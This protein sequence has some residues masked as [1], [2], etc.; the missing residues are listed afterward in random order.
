MMEEKGQRQHVRISVTVRVWWGG[1]RSSAHLL[2]YLVYFVFC[3]AKRTRWLLAAV[4]HRIQ[5][6]EWGLIE[7]LPQVS[8]RKVTL[9]RNIHQSSGIALSGHR[10]H[11]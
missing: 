5:E 10:S 11:S 1:T 7:A 3:D 8:Q 2:R 6:Q 9:S 4:L